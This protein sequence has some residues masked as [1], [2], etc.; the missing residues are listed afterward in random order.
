MVSLAEA[1]MCL[2]EG[3]ST[4]IPL[5]ELASGS[6]CIPQTFHEPLTPLEG[7]MAEFPSFGPYSK[8]LAFWVTQKRDLF[9]APKS[10]LTHQILYPYLVLGNAKFNYCS[11]ILQRVS[12]SSWKS[13]GLHQA[14]LTKVTEF[15]IFLH[16]STVFWQMLTSLY[17]PGTISII[18]CR[19][20]ANM[21][22]WEIVKRSSPL[23]TKL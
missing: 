3:V 20:W 8:W 12:W 19:E 13:L 18:L 2:P 6:M 23:Q 17:F 9:V 15:C 5:L 1:R 14:H 22:F 10:K 21:I 7:H 16:L 11:A 4:A